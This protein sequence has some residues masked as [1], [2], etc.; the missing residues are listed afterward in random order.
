MPTTG[1]S[2]RVVSDI[3]GNVMLRGRMRW[4]GA[5]THPAARAPDGAASS[6]DADPDVVLPGVGL[7]MDLTDSDDESDAA[8]TGEARAPTPAE[9][10][11]RLLCRNAFERATSRWVDGWD[12][13]LRVLRACGVHRGESEDALQTLLRVDSLLAT[14]CG[15]RCSPT[16]FLAGAD[17]VTHKRYVP[18]IGDEGVTERLFYA[19]TP[20]ATVRELRELSATTRVP[21]PP[22]AS[23]GTVDVT[24]ESVALYVA[25]DER[26]SLRTRLQASDRR[27]VVAPSDGDFGVYVYEVDG[28]PAPD[29]VL[30]AT[31]AERRAFKAFD[32]H[33]DVRG[34]YLMVTME[35]DAPYTLDDD[36]DITDRI[37]LELERGG[38]GARAT[39]RDLDLVSVV[40]RAGDDADAHY[41]AVVRDGDR[42]VHVDDAS[43]RQ[44]E[45]GDVHGVCFARRCRPRVLF[46]RVSRVGDDDA[47]AR[48][49]A[50]ECGGDAKALRDALAGAAAVDRPAVEGLQN[51]SLSCHLNAVLVSWFFL[52]P[53]MRALLR[54]ACRRLPVALIAA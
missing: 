16:V 5:T 7:V 44:L 30:E 49:A 35:A 12:E 14:V 11:V 8:A 26:V 50:A 31:D 47:A 13:T 54:D 15:L 4:G 29:A 18:S 39:R 24:R 20:R 19:D 41:T 3:H 25:L 51:L 38:A 2:R 36:D 1:A 28:A 27:V 10:F 40:V 22:S 32:E 46:Y 34:A 17:R 6:R 9:R 33:Y 52:V 45:E 43:C 48:R 53:E 37:V 21:V 42:W 23:A